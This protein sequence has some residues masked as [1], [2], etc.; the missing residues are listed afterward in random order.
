M[1][2]PGSVIR[3][4]P[5]SPYRPK[6]SKIAVQWITKKCVTKKNRGTRPKTSSGLALPSFTRSN[7]PIT[8]IAGPSVIRR[9]SNDGGYFMHFKKEHSV[10]TADDWADHGSGSP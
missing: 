9:K 3:R 6:A 4:R 10:I 5:A 8:V 7:R 1:L 2:I